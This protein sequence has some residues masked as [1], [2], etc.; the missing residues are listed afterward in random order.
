MHVKDRQKYKCIKLNSFSKQFASPLS[1]SPQISNNQM[2][3]FKAIQI[4]ESNNVLLIKAVSHN[5]TLS[6][7]IGNCASLAEV[8]FK[9]APS[10]H[11]SF[12]CILQTNYGK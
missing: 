10:K 6:C 4:M 7:Y 3:H 8:N 11:K 5:A 2:G 9:N 12:H 1:F